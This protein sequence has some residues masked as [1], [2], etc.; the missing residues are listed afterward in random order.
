MNDVIR[1]NVIR[2]LRKYNS[3]DKLGY[4]NFAKTQVVR[5]NRDRLRWNIKF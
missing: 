3:G 4:Q 2:N 5:R 1:Y